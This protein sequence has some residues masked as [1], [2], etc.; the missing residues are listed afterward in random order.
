MAHR[1][2][3]SLRQIV[4]ALLIAAG[5][6]A[7]AQIG[8]QDS[9]L[10]AFLLD[11]AE[12]LDLVADGV[13]RNWISDYV[14]PTGKVLSAVN[15][16]G[17]GLTLAPG[18]SPLGALRM[19]IP[20]TF[21]FLDAGFGVP[22]PAVDGASTLEFPG[23]ITSFERLTFLARYGPDVPDL[24]F[25]VILET[26]PGPD[27]AQLIWSFQPALGSTFEPVEIDLRSPAF[28]ANGGSET[29]ESLLSQT[30]FLAFHA[31]SGMLSMP[32]TLD[33]HIDDI[34]LAGAYQPPDPFP[35]GLHL[36]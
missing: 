14:F 24:T 7:H 4:V 33:L 11:D 21:E 20:G 32:Q 2:R 35:L 18:Q 36:R 6:A 10:G 5:I 15:L 25:F 28:V 31:S 12:D 23:D 29:L 8:G 1:A 9:S 22:M 27:H 17:S 34:R 13:E 16:N 3:F 30:R 19:R 26:Y